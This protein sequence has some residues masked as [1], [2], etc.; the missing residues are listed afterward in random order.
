MPNFERAMS[1]REA[2]IK[3]QKLSIFVKMEKN[4][5]MFK[6]TLIHIKLRPHCVTVWVGRESNW[7]ANL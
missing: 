3:S 1:C 7:N 2:D 5:K 4:M 6:Y